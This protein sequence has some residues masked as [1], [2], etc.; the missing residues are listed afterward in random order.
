MYTHTYIHIHISGREARGG[1]P[2]HIVSVF[3][4]WNI[5]SIHIH[6]HIHIYTYTH[7]CAL[8]I[9]YTYIYIY[10]PSGSQEVA[11]LWDARG[12]AA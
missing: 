11:V 10:L 2:H 5:Y 3:A 9:V 1:S 4:I 6:I 7:T 8:Y 12:R